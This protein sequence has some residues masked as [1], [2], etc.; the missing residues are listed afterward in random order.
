MSRPKKALPNH[1]D[2]Y[3]V[4]VT[5]GK[6]PKGHTIRK[7]AYSTKSKRDAELKAQKLRDD[8]IKGNLQMLDEQTTLGEYAE[9]WLEAV[10]R[11]HVRDNTFDYTYKNTV[12][13]HL[14]PAFGDCILSRIQK[15]DINLFLNRNTNLSQSLIHNM[16]ITL[17]QIFE[18]AIDNHILS[19]NPCRHVKEPNSKQIPKVIIPYTKEQDET[20]FNF[21]K[22]DPAGLSICILLKAGLRRGE[23]LGLRW[24]DVDLEHSVI[25][26]CQALTETN[27]V[28]KIDEPKNKTSVRDVPI[29]SELKD[30]LENAPRSVKRYV[31]CKDNPNKRIHKVIQNEF[32]ISNIYGNAMRPSSWQKNVY[33]KFTTDLK[34]A[35]PEI[36]ILRAHGLRHTFGSRL[37]N[38]G[39]RYDIYT[40][41]KIMGHANIEITTEIY[42]KHDLDYIEKSFKYDL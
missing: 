10:K 5:L 40:I 20:V 27:G 6:D 30:V 18:D 7:S 23:L 32:V 22:T 26:I 21:A 38:N 25:H 3:E 34:Q 15:I 36:P 12:K 39:Q 17:N 13:N 33:E 4:K 11:D 42:V 31:R 9:R 1:G 8:F 29:F 2:R 14:I 35:H 41:S 24:T 19:Q 37:Y 16:K 28:V